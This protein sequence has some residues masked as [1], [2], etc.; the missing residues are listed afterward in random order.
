MGVVL[1]WLGASLAAGKGIFLC[2]IPQHAGQTHKNLF[3]IFSL[4]PQTKICSMGSLVGI[5]LERFLEK[6]G[7]STSGWLIGLL[8]PT[9]P[10]ASGWKRKWN[11]VYTE[12]GFMSLDDDV[13][14][15]TYVVCDYVPPKMEWDITVKELNNSPV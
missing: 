9:K 5:F 2:L 10:T 15:R 14:R 8:R 11:G 12:K 13:P 1:Q 3:D 7:C 4:Y 6:Q